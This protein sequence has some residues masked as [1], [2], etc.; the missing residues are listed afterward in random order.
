M[1]RDLTFVP[2][3]GTAWRNIVG[4]TV[5]LDISLTGGTNGSVVDVCMVMDVAFPTQYCNALNDMTHRIA[6]DVEHG[7]TPSFHRKGKNPPSVSPRKAKGTRSEEYHQSLHISNLRT[8]L[9]LHEHLKGNSMQR[10]RHQP[11]FTQDEDEYLLQD[12][13]PTAA[14]RLYYTMARQLLERTS[15][16]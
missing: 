6:D 12:N 13:H 8:I 11:R 1:Q 7:T 10:A 3:G 15:R 14:P 9:V 2:H 5:K 4:T 16:K